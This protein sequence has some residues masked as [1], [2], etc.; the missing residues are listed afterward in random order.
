MTVASS[1]A[2]A[3]SEGPPPN[4]SVQEKGL[5]SLVEMGVSITAA[6]VDRQGCGSRTYSFGGSVNFQGGGSVTVDDLRLTTAVTVNDLRGTFFQT[7]IPAEGELGDL[8]VRRSPTALR[9]AG[10]VGDFR[11]SR[12]GEIAY[13]DAEFD[14]NVNSFGSIYERHDEHI[15]KDFFQSSNVF[16]GLPGV[17]D[18]GLEVITKLDYPRAKWRQVSEYYRADGGIGI[19]SITKTLIAPDNAASCQIQINQ[20]LVDDFGDGLQI[21]GTVSVQRI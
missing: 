16:G 21:S 8:A 20:A 5:F 13:G 7:D 15:I 19:L 3:Q 12:R 4:L 17:E 6:Q 14:L 9:H 11:Y 18:R 2:F 10:Y 1:A